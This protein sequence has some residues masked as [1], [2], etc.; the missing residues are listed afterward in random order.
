MPSPFPGMDP[1]L[2]STLYFGG[3]HSS[4]ITYIKAALQSRLPEPYYAESD[5]RVYVDV[6][7]RYVEPDVNLI[8]RELPA[9]PDANGSVAIATRS[10]PIVV[11]PLPVTESEEITESYVNILT[12]QAGR[13]RIVASIEILSPSN[14]A[15][16]AGMSEYR[17]KQREVRLTREIHL[18]EIDLLRAGIHT[19]LVPIELL[20]ARAGTHDYHVCVSRFDRPSEAI[21]YPF[22]LQDRLPEIALPLLPGEGEVPLDLQTTLD[23]AYDAGPYRRRVLYNEPPDPPLTAEQQTWAAD[24]LRMAGLLP[25]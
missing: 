1:W 15:T 18:V 13:E 16:G 14:K 5:D 21:L 12:R 7:F 9:R 19:T 8:R 20:R 11:E 6:S 10:Q 22:R 2:E 24:Y 17:K 25:K 4:M 3:L 23:Q